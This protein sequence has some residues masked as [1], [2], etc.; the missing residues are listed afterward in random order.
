MQNNKPKIKLYSFYYKKTPILKKDN[1]YQPIMAGC[2][3]IENNIQI[4][5]DNTGD[6]ISTKNKN[7]SELT[8]LYWVW[9]NETSDIIGS[10]HYRRYFTAQPEPFLYQLKR[11]LYYPIGLFRKRYGLIYTSNTALFIPRIINQTEI[12]T[13][14]NR[15]DAILPRARRLKYTIEEHY[16]RYHNSKDLVILE[17]ILLRKHPDYIDYYHTLLKSKKLYANNMFI[18]RK[19]HFNELMTWWFDILFEFEKQTNIN[20]Y[21]GYQ[22]RVLGFIAERLLSLWFLK[23]QLNIIELNVIYFKHQKKL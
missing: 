19:Q 4:Q 6:N 21:T 23:R 16:K 13:L 12:E 15:Y 7:Y 5:G 18:L 22:E 20:Q 14:M 17:S 3:S 2:K 1:I 11:L 8:G 10:C 9:K